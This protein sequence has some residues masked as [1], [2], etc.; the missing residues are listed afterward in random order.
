[1]GNVLWRDDHPHFVDFDDARSGPAIQDLWMLLSGPDIDQVAQWEAIMRGYQVLRDF[2]PSEIGLIEP[3]RTLRLIH[4][5]AWVSRRWREPA[6]QRAFAFI[7]SEKFWSEHILELRE[8]LGELSA[9]TSQLAD[10]LRS[11]SFQQRF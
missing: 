9:G 8:Q 2:D 11:V 4:H 7:G 1:M 10:Q 6:F 5:A 3:L